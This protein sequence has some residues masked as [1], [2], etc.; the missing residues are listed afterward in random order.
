MRYPT[1]KTFKVTYTV[2]I[3][4]RTMLVEDQ[5]IT[6]AIRTAYDELDTADHTI[7]KIEQI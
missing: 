2:E 3:G 5:D 4:I 6:S 7:I 1:I